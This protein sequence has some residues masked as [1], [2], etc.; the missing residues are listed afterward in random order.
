MTDPAG[1]GCSRGPPNPAVCSKGPDGPR[2]RG[3]PGVVSDWFPLVFVATPCIYE[4]E[5]QGEG[6]L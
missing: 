5:T 6:K 1:Q 3:V 2:A 4:Q